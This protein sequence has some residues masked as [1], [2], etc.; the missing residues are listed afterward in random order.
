MI[1]DDEIYWMS[2]FYCSFVK[3]FEYFDK[4]DMFAVSKM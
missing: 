3:K 4:F 2:N 1:S